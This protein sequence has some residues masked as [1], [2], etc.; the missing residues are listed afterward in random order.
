LEDDGPDEAAGFE[1]DG[2]EEHAEKRAATKV[3][4]I[5]TDR[6]SLFLFHLII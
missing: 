4:I 1:D 2:C 5:R 3:I 6:I